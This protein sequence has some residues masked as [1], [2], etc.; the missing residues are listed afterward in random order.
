MEYNHDPSFEVIRDC[1]LDNYQLTPNFTANSLDD[2][3]QFKWLPNKKDSS[4][5]YI[6][7]FE[8]KTSTSFYEIIIYTFDL[9]IYP[10]FTESSYQFLSGKPYQCLEKSIKYIYTYIEQDKEKQ[11]KEGKFKFLYYLSFFKIYLS[12]FTEFLYPLLNMHKRP[13][14]K[15]AR[16][17][18]LNI[19]NLLL[20]PQNNETFVEQTKNYILKLI[21]H[22]HSP[23]YSH[24][25]HL[26]WS[27]MP[28]LVV[29]NIEMFSYILPL[30]NFNLEKSSDSITEYNELKK[31]IFDSNSVSQE[32][33][34]EKIS[35]VD[36]FFRFFDISINE[37]L[38]SFFLDND[39]YKMKYTET[40]KFFEK[41]KDYYASV[42]QDFGDNYYELHLLIT[43][44]LR[45][46]DQFKPH[47]QLSPKTREIKFYAYKY[48]FS[49][50]F[51][52]KG[53]YYNQ[54]CLEERNKFNEINCFPGIEV[55][56]NNVCLKNSLEV[57]KVKD[58]SPGLFHICS[59][60]STFFFAGCGIPNSY[61][62]CPRCKKTVGGNEQHELYEREG[63]YIVI[64][65]NIS[66]IQKIDEDKCR[67]FKI[68]ENRKINLSTLEH[69]VKFPLPAKEQIIKGLLTQPTSNKKLTDL[70]LHFI[71][72]SIL[73][74]TGLDD[75][76]KELELK[77]HY[78]DNDLLDILELIWDD[79][80]KELIISNC[81]GIQCFLN[82]TFN[83]IRSLMK[84]CKIISDTDKINFENEVCEKV[85]EYVEKYNLY[86]KEYMK[87]KQKLFP[88]I[89][90][91]L[92]EKVDIPQSVEGINCFY[93]SSY[94]RESNIK[95]ELDLLSPEKK[96]RYPLLCA[97]YD[98]KI[99]E[100]IESLKSIPLLNPFINYM[101]DKYSFKLTRIEALEHKLKDVFNSFKDTEEEQKE[102][103]SVIKKFEDYKK[104][105]EIIKNSVTR[106]ECDEK[107]KREEISEEDNLN[108][109]LNDSGEEGRGSY[110]FI[111]Y[112]NLCHYQ[113]N[114]INKFI[115]PFISRKSS[116]SSQILSEQ[117]HPP[118]QNPDE[119]QG[120]IQFLIESF[121]KEILI[122]DA[123]EHDILTFDISKV[124]SPYYSMLDLIS[125]FSYRRITDKS[126]NVDYSH[127]RKIIYNFELIEFELE[128]IFLIGKSSFSEKQ[129]T[130]LFCGEIFASDM[131]IFE[132]FEKKYMQEELGS[133]KQ[134]L[135]NYLESKRA[136]MQINS[137]DFY[138]NI[139]NSILALALFALKKKNLYT[140]QPICKIIQ[141]N[142][143]KIDLNKSCI[144]LFSKNENEKFC[145]CH[146]KKIFEYFEYLYVNS[147][148][149]DLESRYKMKI[150]ETKIEN[151]K[152]YFKRNKNSLI[153]KDILRD[154]IGRFI[155]R[156]LVYNILE[157]NSQR[158]LIEQLRWGNIYWP[159]KVF[160]QN[161]FQEEFESM[162][163][164][165]QLN[166][167]EIGSLYELLNKNDS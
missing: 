104:G 72:F 29:K 147:S 125:K 118:V 85:S 149:K 23:Y 139:Y 66:E 44:F 121:E 157:S 88:N 159:Q 38:A 76:E 107:E 82:A 135:D 122:Q 129:K 101:I 69:L 60:M 50:F 131:T 108:F 97:Y 132:Q 45:K 150:K 78:K 93:L 10:A 167:E 153:T 79:I 115:K 36:N 15:E 42:R 46:N 37:C 7:L 58:N 75:N 30:F 70:L 11:N 68:P 162:N 112:N 4:I 27:L 136:Q 43:S 20:N 145:L 24:M 117:K 55:N 28:K 133:D 57:L 67:T 35:S 61:S 126:G 86:Y 64:R 31:I 18:I 152:S 95:K 83:S 48:L 89:Y 65:D 8:T 127:Y 21:F 80:E 13:I 142:K 63:Y 99:R 166:I 160:E 123:T 59:C 81:P 124:N 19:D 54:F 34:N 49:S 53:S 12:K 154:A 71:L 146:L 143:K 2:F 140:K 40:S 74:T 1:L 33:I 130:M 14:P 47:Q 100:E 148:M 73:Y 102:K 51:A 134:L 155:S 137:T 25:L 103:Q 90:E 114:V 165:L 62:E 56:I 77:E 128:K 116:M 138:Q 113:M 96:E 119:K 109:F 9:A 3:G 52:D 94:C 17:F 91:M 156:K 120:F 161:N 16:E 22:D 98:E 41:I 141:E 32:I 111:A 163:Q 5:D 105:W 158:K 144:D 110:N 39:N 151:I 106:Y 164:E 84:K 6:S 26:N 87:I 92:I